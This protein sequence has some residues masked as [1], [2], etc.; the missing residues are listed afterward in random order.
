MR[1]LSLFTTNENL[2]ELFRNKKYESY[3][4]Y[5]MKKSKNVFPGEYEYIKEQSK[6]EPDFI[7]ANLGTKY[8]AKLPSFS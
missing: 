4:F 8:D 2:I 5:L 1:I 6:G 7:E 3:V